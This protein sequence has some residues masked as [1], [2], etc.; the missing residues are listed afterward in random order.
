MLWENMTF[1]VEAGVE[2]KRKENLVQDVP[3]K[4]KPDSL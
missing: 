4:M 1:F 3:C 2:Q